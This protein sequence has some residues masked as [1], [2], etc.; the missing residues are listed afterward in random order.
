MKKE[1]RY[2][3]FFTLEK[4]V[5]SKKKIAVLKSEMLPEFFAELIAD[6]EIDR[7]LKALI[8]TSIS[9]GLRI[10]EALSLK[11]GDFYPEDDI[12]FAES[13]VLKKRKDDERLIM[14]H[15][16][17]KDFLWQYVQDKIGPLFGYTRDGALKAVK[18][19]FDVEG[20]CN[21]SWRHTMISFFLFEVNFSREKTAKLMHVSVNIIDRYAHLNEKKALR[22]AF[23]VR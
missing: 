17:A 12:L 21:H 4:R 3:R 1:N 7:S 6:A 20:I 9:G 16:A 19:V 8:V 14:I 18:R 22:E 15:P 2:A 23:A 13:S 10:T 11:K 5:N